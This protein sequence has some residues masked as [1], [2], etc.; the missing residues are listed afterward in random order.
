MYKF[1][2]FGRDYSIL[3]ADAVQ[4]YQ[5]GIKC[6][7]ISNLMNV[8]RRTIGKWLKEAGFVYSKNNK[9]NINSEIFETIDTQEKAYWLGFIYADGYVSKESNFELSLSIK[10]LSHL[11]KFKSFLEFEG[12]IY[13][14]QKV[15]RCRLQ[16]RD[17]KIVNSLKQL[18]CVNKKSLILR[19]PEVS[20]DLKSHFIRGY[21]EGDGYIS[22]PKRSVA[23]SI[24]GT[25]EFLKSIHD[26]TDLPKEN[27]KHRNPKHSK[28]VFTN[29]ISGKNARKL[30]RYMYEN[31]TVYLDRKYQRVIDHLKKFENE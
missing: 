13:I 16:F 5:K 7:Q 9:A 18:G 26:V 21:F 14:D 28:E 4:H 30:C 31:A 10:D 2:K 19:F 27:I 22:D 17:V 6:V 12:K 24:V 3:K 11:E 29:M 20:D 8:D 15:G 25:E 23:V 1:N